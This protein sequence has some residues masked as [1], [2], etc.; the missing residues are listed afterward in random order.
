MSDGERLHWWQTRWFVVAMAVAATI[1]LWW[2]DIP[3]LVDLP[4]HM[5]RY[6]VQLAINDHP[7]LAQWYDFRWQLIGNLGVDLL[8]EP[9]AR[10]LGLELSVKLVV[11]AIPALIVAGLLW[12]AREVHGRIPASITSG[13]VRRRA[14]VR[15]PGRA[16]ATLPQAPRRRSRRS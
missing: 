9:L 7:H 2:P 1:P 13:R 14:S 10:L 8:I 6:R 11:M 12:I 16:A 15:S 4:G 3:P 5:G